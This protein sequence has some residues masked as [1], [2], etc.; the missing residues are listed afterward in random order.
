MYLLGSETW[1]VPGTIQVHSQGSTNPLSPFVDYS[2]TL[3]FS[4][5]FSKP[6]WI[7]PR[8][9]NIP[10]NFPSPCGIFQDPGTFLGIFQAPGIFLGIF[11]KNTSTS[12]NINFSSCC[13]RYVPS[14]DGDPEPSAS[15]Q[16]V[17]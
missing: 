8:P 17:A 16:N 12:P 6:P 7:F 10:W 15:V 5:E 11:R 3:E 1:N 14:I 9:W 2:R 13:P 4:S